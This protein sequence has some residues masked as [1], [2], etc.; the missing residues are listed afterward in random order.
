MNFIIYYTTDDTCDFQIYIYSF[1]IALL[2]LPLGIIL[3]FLFRCTKSHYFVI[4]TFCFNCLI[5]FY[6]NIRRRYIPTLIVL[7]NIEQQNDSE[8]ENLINVP[9]NPK[10]HPLQRK[11]KSV[12][13][14]DQS[15]IIG[16]AGDNANDDFSDISSNFSIPSTNIN[17]LE[18]WLDDQPDTFESM[19]V[20][21]LSEENEMSIEDR[22]AL[23]RIGYVHA[24]RSVDPDSFVYPGDHGILELEYLIDDEI[25]DHLIQSDM[26]LQFDKVGIENVS[27]PQ[28][29]LIDKEDDSAEVLN[30]DLVQVEEDETEDE[31][32][33]SE[34]QYEEK[35][36]LNFEFCEMSPANKTGCF[37]PWWFIFITWLLC[38]VTIFI[39]LYFTMIYGLEIS[40]FKSISWLIGIASTVVFSLLL[41]QPLSALIWAFVLAFCMVS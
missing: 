41:S 40:Y 12:S 33:K 16:G 36:Y 17:D 29:Q 31:K 21:L 11:T 13:E 14:N 23:G 30:H 2:D 34:E 32:I 19:D 35:K 20:R 39:C 1:V 22:I 3:L 28:A 4:E 5:Q 37:F 25:M 8:I 9:V 27:I 15:S 38:L 10:P 7:G 18:C 26:T 6:S 24:I